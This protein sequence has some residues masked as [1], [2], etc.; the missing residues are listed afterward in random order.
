MRDLIKF[1]NMGRLS[2][3]TANGLAYILALVVSMAM[4]PDVLGHGYLAVPLSR[5]MYSRLY[6][7]DATKEYTP[8]QLSAGGVAVVSA[9]S[10]LTWPFGAYSVCGNRA[11]DPNPR[12]MVPRPIQAT[13]YEGDIINIT[14]GITADHRGRFAFRL[15]PTTNVTNTCLNAN[16]L[17]RADPVRPG[18]R[19]WYLTDKTRADGSALVTLQSLGGYSN[20]P[21][22]TLRYRLPAGV[23]CDNCVLQWWWPTANSCTL[24]CV[25]EDPDFNPASGPNSCNVQKLGICGSSP[26]LFPEEFWN[27]ADIRILPRGAASSPPS[28]AS[29]SPKPAPTAAT[30]PTSFPPPSPS[31]KPSPPLLSPSPSPKAV[32]PPPAPNPSSPTTCSTTGY[33]AGKAAG[34]YANPCDSTCATYIQCGNDVTYLMTCGSGLVFNPGPK[35]CD[36]PY[37]YKCPAVSPSPSPAPSPVVSSP[38]PPP[39]KPSPSTNPSPSA[40]SPPPKSPPPTPSPKPTSYPSPAPNSPPPAETPPPPIRL[41]PPSPSPLPPIRLPPPIPSPLPPIRLAPPSP[42]PLPPPVP[43]PSPTTCTTTGYCGGKAAGLYANPCDAACVTY[44]QCANDVTYLK[45]CGSGLVFNPGPK[46]CDWPYNYKCPAVSPSPAP[47]SSPSPLPSPSSSPAPPPLVRPSPPLLSRPSPPPTSSP[48]P[49]PSPSPTPSPGPNPSPSPSPTPAPPAGSYKVVGYLETWRWYQQGSVPPSLTAHLPKLTHINYAFI[50]ISYSPQYDT[51][52]LDFTDPWADVGACLTGTGTCPASCL[53]LNATCGGSNLGM[54]PT[55]KTTGATCP[56]GC[57]NRG[58]GSSNRICNTVLSGMSWPLQACGH[59]AYVQNFISKS[60]PNVRVLLSVGGWYDSNYFSMATA[61]AYR[62]R[63][64]DSIVD[65]MDLFK[66]DGVDF[67]WEYPGFEHGGQPPYGM[68]DYGSPDDVRDCSATTCTYGS[69]LQDGANYVAFLQDLRSRLN[70]RRSWRGQPFL[71][72]MAGPS[73]TDKLN[74]MTLSSICAQLDWVNIMTYDLHGPWDTTTGHQSALS[75]PSG[76]PL[77]V[78]AVVAQY[79]ARGCPKSK[80][81]V[82]VPFYGRSFAGVQAGPDTTLPGY[83]QPFTGTAADPMPMQKTI[84]ALGYRTVY[85]NARNASYAYDATSKTFITYD[86]EAAVAAKAAYVKRE[87]LAGVMAWA[88]GQETPQLWTA[89]TSGL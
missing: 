47:S 29:P 61:P 10:T 8:N 26:A 25:P 59:V 24:P 67:D 73:G 35:Y 77:T 22:Y 19:Y 33:C 53:S 51:Y 65:F 60:A 21:T 83:N 3:N 80:I 49:N 76:D 56:T 79:V 64:I 87:G 74:K 9:G 18:D 52:Y 88:L 27:C 32:M 11:D 42:S 78:S 16:W 36:W 48:A 37:N 66:F 89:L 45:T 4:P 68:S 38:S 1:V 28:P 44:I 5:N 63:F 82:G 30:P 23:T 62:S 72:T 46:Y 81:V 13:Y 34:L 55:V 17:T 6:D 15:C 12:W 70:G 86:N 40:A 58:G 7:P 31:P 84:A 57:F 85:E 71:M 2:R 54:I 20:V 41:P 75:D 69:R 14:I 50:S 43:N 39:P